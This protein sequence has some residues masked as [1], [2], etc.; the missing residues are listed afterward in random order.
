MRL[1]PST[2]KLFVSPVVFKDCTNG[3]LGNS[4]SFSD[5]YAYRMAD[6]FGDEI[7]LELSLVNSA[8]AAVGKDDAPQTL[9]LEKRYGSTLLK[10]MRASTGFHDLEIVAADGTRF[11]CHR[12][13]FATASEVWTAM[14]HSNMAERQSGVVTFSEYSAAALL[15]I[16]RHDS[17]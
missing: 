7:V 9:S 14:L 10:Q 17:R 4:M 6:S 1:S 8:A 11:S 2:P 12:L 3:K 15:E 5:Q 13:V 16:L